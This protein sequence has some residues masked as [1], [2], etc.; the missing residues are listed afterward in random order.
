[1]RYIVKFT[2]SNTDYPCYIAN[3]QISITVDN[4][5]WKGHPYSIQKIGRRTYLYNDGIDS[6][7]DTLEQC[8]A[9]AEYEL[10]KNLAYTENVNVS[11]L[12]NYL[13]EENDVICIEDSNNG[14]IDNYQIE[15][16]TIPVKPKL[17]ELTCKKIRRVI[18]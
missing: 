1:M 5:P 10:R 3:L 18:E 11:I 14:C 8:N 9:R 15:S 17:M 2:S 12:P 13:L 4:K 6:N 7:I 16:F